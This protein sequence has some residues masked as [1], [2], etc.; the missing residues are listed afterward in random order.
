MP[1]SGSHPILY[2]FRES[3][4]GVYCKFN[5]SY[6]PVRLASFCETLQSNGIPDD[7]VEMAAGHL[8]RDNNP[9]GDDI[10]QELCIK[11]SVGLSK[12]PKDCTSLL[13]STIEYSVEYSTE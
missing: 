7:T 8:A 12:V 3:R 13:C 9:E 2:A 10:N 6:T 5:E 4:F 11:L 1:F